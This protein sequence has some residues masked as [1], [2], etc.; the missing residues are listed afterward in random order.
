MKYKILTIC[1]FLNINILLNAD[2]LKK[3]VIMIKYLQEKDG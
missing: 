2:Y 3:G 1:L